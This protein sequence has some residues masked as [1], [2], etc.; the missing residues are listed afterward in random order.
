MHRKIIRAAVCII[1]CLSL[2]APSVLAAGTGTVNADALNLRSEPNTGST[3]KALIYKGSYLVVTGSKGDWYD[4]IYDGTQGF[5]HSDYVDYAYTESGKY[6]T[7]G[8]VRGMSV[9]FRSGP[10][11]D[12]RVLGYYNT[13]ARFTVLGIDGDW[14]RVS[15]EAGIIGY[16]HSDYINCSAS[17]NV[18][19]SNY[20]ARGAE[21]ME[22]AKLYL[23]VPYVWGGMSPYGFD[24]SGF[25]N[26]VYNSYGY[27]LWRV[28]QD[29]YS[30]D[31]IHVEKSELRA[32]DIICFG[33]GPRSISHVGMYIGNGRFIHA[34]S[35]SGCVV[36]SDLVGYYDRMYVG[37]K[38]IIG[39]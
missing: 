37:A 24:C 8:T 11:L 33:Y 25:V 28:A 7:T 12:S 9:R 39:Q 3:V 23:G 32:G 27:S 18:L 30:F 6:G 15:T 38:R 19:I 34:S 31:G 26:Y 10:S 36:I 5:V 29:I 17:S 22:N 16:I 13:G 14:V 1:L 4:V 2:L 21:M 20:D 35:G